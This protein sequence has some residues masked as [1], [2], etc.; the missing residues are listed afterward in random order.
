MKYLDA[1]TH[2]TCF[3]WDIQPPALSVNGEKKSNWW[4]VIL[5]TRDFA[6]SIGGLF[7]Q[8]YT[9]IVTKKI[10]L[11]YT[12]IYIY[13]DRREVDPSNRSDFT[14]LRRGQTVFNLAVLKKYSPIYH[15]VWY[16]SLHMVDSYYI[17]VGKFIQC[18]N[19]VQKKYGLKRLKLVRHVPDSPGWDPVFWGGLKHQFR[20]CLDVWCVLQ[21]N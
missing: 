1:S 7:E 4:K 21:T 8:L 13:M 10:V 14:H 12:Y 3:R 17:N 20:W 2:P 9:S 5:R 11:N 6:A 16:I 18:M 19:P 15:H